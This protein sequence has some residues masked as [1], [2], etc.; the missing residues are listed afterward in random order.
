MLP[1]TASGAGGAPP[2]PSPAASD[3]IN[4]AIVK[5]MT[6]IYGSSADPAPLMQAL[7]TQVTGFL[8]SSSGP[9]GG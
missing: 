2:T 6:Q 3:A 4:S 1:P 8:S 5:T 9:G 7:N